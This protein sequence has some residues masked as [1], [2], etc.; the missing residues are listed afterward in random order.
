[1]SRYRQG[2]YYHSIDIVT[3]AKVIDTQGPRSHPPILLPGRDWA[4][5]P[6]HLGAGIVGK[7]KKYMCIGNIHV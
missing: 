2:H 3:A 6:L 4:L 7:Q 5:K 1:M